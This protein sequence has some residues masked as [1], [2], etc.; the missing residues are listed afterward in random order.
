MIPTEKGIHLP[1]LTGRRQ[2]QLKFPAASS[3]NDN[4]LNA[5]H[6]DK[7]S[8]LQDEGLEISTGWH[9]SLCDA[10]SS[11]ERDPK[12]RLHVRS[13]AHTHCG[14]TPHPTTVI[15][16]KYSSHSTNAISPAF[17]HM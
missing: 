13:Q 7:Q 6:V 11:I 1:P 12:K 10:P 5:C 9:M 3:C 16:I 15:F 14:M 8:V 2:F 4:V 17:H